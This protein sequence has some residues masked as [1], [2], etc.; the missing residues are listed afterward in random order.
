MRRVC[1]AW[2]CREPQK[3]QNTQKGLARVMERP[4]APFP[5]CDPLCLL[6]LLPCCLGT[7]RG[8]QRSEN[9][10]RRRTHRRVTFCVF[11][12]CFSALTDTGPKRPT[13]ARDAKVRKPQKAQKTQ[14]GL[15]CR[16]GEWSCDA[17]AARGHAAL[18]RNR[19]FTTACVALPRPGLPCSRVDAIVRR[20]CP[21]PPTTLNRAR[22]VRARRQPSRRRSRSPATCEAATAP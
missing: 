19:S 5:F 16:I 11:C 14:K 7:F 22:S 18:R 8:T 4:P 12:G 2:S 6:W 20:T 13:W 15:A 17:S 1:S 21:P 10:R 9:H 3:A